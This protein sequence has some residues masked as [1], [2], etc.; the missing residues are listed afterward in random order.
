MIKVKTVFILSSVLVLGLLLLQFVSAQLVPPVGQSA[1]ITKWHVD[2]TEDESACGGG[3]STKS[4][5][6]QIQ[7][8][9]KMAVVGDWEHGEMHGAFAGNTISIAGKPIRDGTGTSKL[10]NINILFNP[11]CSGF[12][13]R[14]TWDYT[15]PQMSCSGSTTLRGT[16]TDGKGCP[17]EEQKPQ[18]VQNPPANNLLPVNDA[19]AD[20]NKLLLLLKEKKDLEL[21]ILLLEEEGVQKEK[22][23]LLAE[24]YKDLSSKTAQVNE[25][26][27]KVE[28]KYKKITNKDPDNF[29]ANWDLA[30]L[31]KN[32]GNYKASIDYFD[33]AA[34]NDVFP[35]T[36][37]ELKKNA[38]K[39]LGLQEFPSIIKSSVV[40]KI[41]DDM[42][43]GQD[44]RVYDVSLPID[45]ATKEPTRW[46]KFKAK[47]WTV[48]FPE[49][50]NIAYKLA[51][52]QPPQ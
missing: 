19:R 21:K 15:D 28:A 52:L 41:S 37:N 9:P 18:P 30:E 44:V 39:D 20:L 2:V 48:L 42:H 35:S 34:S 17:E 8:G 51:G 6:V 4:R 24:L 45:E 26:Q 7:H 14:Y 12:S 29:W 50:D 46:E 22:S 5:S 11:D 47:V 40:R 38:A 31:E 32:K 10:S 3:V 43:T 25:L 1:Q 36:S 33:R 23:L 16:R 13:S 49:A 27:P